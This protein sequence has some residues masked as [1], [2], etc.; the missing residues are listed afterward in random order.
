MHWRGSDPIG[1]KVTVM[2]Y[3]F[4][5]HNSLLTSRL[6]ISAL[7]CPIKR[8]FGMLFMYA[9]SR[10]AF[11][12]HKKWMVDDVLLTLFKFYPNNCQYLKF[13][14]TYKLHTW[15]QYQHTAYLINKV[16]VTFTD[17]KGHRWRSKITNK[18]KWSYLVNLYTNRHH[19]WY[20]GT[21]QYETS[22]YISFLYLTYGQG[23]ASL[24]RPNCWRCLHFLNASCFLF[25]VRLSFDFNFHFISFHFMFH[26]F[27]I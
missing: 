13:S 12:F 25:F 15:Y 26:W 6:W 21:K 16:K 2:Q 1:D 27:R 22:N 23:H 7:L 9:L 11:E 10:L 14:W 3:T 8:K 19:I 17:A 18:W 5:L 4:F 24:S 20:Q